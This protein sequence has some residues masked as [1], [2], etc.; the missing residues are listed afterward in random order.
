MPSYRD[1]YRR[2]NS[3]DGHR[4]NGGAPVMT[5]EL[6]SRRERAL[7]RLTNA[8]AADLVS[9]EDYEIRAAS[10][11][12]ARNLDEVERLTADLPRGDR[13]PPTRPL[14]GGRRSPRE[15]GSLDREER[16]KGNLRVANPVDSGLAG[17]QTLA[18]VMGDRHMSGDWLN[19]DRVECFTLM[20]STKIDFRDTTL[21]AGRVRLD[22]FV[23]M[24]ETK[25]IVP[26][27]LP[28][29]LNL[30]PFMGEARISPEVEQRAIPGE[31]CVEISGLALMGSVV[32]VTM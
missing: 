32:V 17:S 30:V 10:I 5:G 9:M 16:G 26:P 28:V 2:E 22:A 4:P 25:I 12:N 18:C 7:E 6:E 1:S 8:F 3:D 31:P 14:A 21:P 29:R 15:R 13:E 19:G 23:L 27:G 20:G 24:G 11:Q